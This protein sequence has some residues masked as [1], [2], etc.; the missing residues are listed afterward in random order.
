MVGRQK[1]HQPPLKTATQLFI[2]GVILLLAAV[3]IPLFSL[4]CTDIEG[5]QHCVK[6]TYFGMNARTFAIVLAVL[7]ALFFC[8]GAFHFRRYKHEL[9]ASQSTDAPSL[10]QRYRHD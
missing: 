4:N 5:V 8:A 6:A 9:K 1:G 10:L 7:S 3:I 2:L